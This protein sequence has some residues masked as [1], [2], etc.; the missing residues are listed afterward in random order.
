[1][2]SQS[3]DGLDSGGLSPIDEDDGYCGDRG[4]IRSS[5]QYGGECG[6][7][8]TSGH[9]CDRSEFDGNMFLEPR[10]D[11]S[12]PRAPSKGKARSILL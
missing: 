4:E 9:F 7:G 5:S 10:R 2:P 12:E 3:G 1:M 6:V 8:T 11:R